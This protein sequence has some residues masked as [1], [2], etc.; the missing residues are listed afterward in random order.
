MQSDSGAQNTEC[1]PE[2]P[3][4]PESLAEQLSTG[5]EH[6]KRGELS[7]A[8]TA[9]R[10]VLNF[11][12]EYPAALHLLGVVAQQTGQLDSAVALIRR[13]INIAPHNPQF[14]SDLGN[15]LAMSG[16]AGA[17]ELAYTEAIRLQ[18][19]HAVT[20]TN[21]G[22]LLSSQGRLEEA[23][24]TLR[25]AV[26]GMSPLP[27]ALA[28][29]GGVLVQL[30]QL[31]EASEVCRRAITLDYRNATAFANL[32]AG[33]RAMGDTAKAIEAAQRAIELEPT[34]VE[35]YT[36]LTALLLD[37]GDVDAAERSCHKSLS[38]R[39][40]RAD[41][42]YNL[43][44]I[45]YF[46]GNQGEAV[47][48]YQRAIALDPGY[49]EAHLALG[50]IRLAERDLG[51]FWAVYSRRWQSRDYNSFRRNFSLPRWEGEDLSGKSILIWGEQGIGDELFFAGLVPEVAA[52]ARACVLETEPRLVTLLQRSL[53]NVTVV[54]R[55]DPA[56]EHTTNPKLDVQAPSGDLGRWLRPSYDGFRPLGKYLTAEPTMVTE[57][58]QRY[59]AL[60]NG[61]CI[62]IAWS[63]RAAKQVPLVDWG[64]VLDGL[65]FPIVSLQYGEHSE[66]IDE[67]ERRFGVQIFADDE[68]DPLTDMDQFAAQVDAVDVVI[69]ID[70]S[71]L[72]VAAALDK[73]TFVMLPRFA[74]WRYAGP[75]GVCPWHGSLR[76]FRQGA[77]GVWG[78]VVAKTGANFRAW[79]QKT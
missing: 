8:E 51:Q 66:E 10:N 15:A 41:T 47:A 19:D 52:C 21:L 23:A 42:H 31:D 45:E 72:A 68:V 38:L 11:D 43:G 35:G 17:A 78:P 36:T 25:R 61:P 5:V 12:R 34:L 62:G 50:R 28:N 13:A 4:L 56:H 24:W 74:D 54:G 71:T 39:E 53:P 26:N 32:A 60:G 48:A 3:I 40:N 22:G 30:G 76:T 20:L 70:N 57:L 55:T 73:P 69:T 9:Y 18:P 14:F 59:R 2:V 67:A 64:P 49:A 77:N 37:S 63:S 33:L 1:G 7:A 16:D 27:D 75:G 44:N 29:L 46:R 58:R 65:D 6:H 79:L